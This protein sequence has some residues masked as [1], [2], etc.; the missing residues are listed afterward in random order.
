VYSEAVSNK[1]LIIMLCRAGR[2]I[3]RVVASSWKSSLVT[4]MS[5]ESKAN[6]DKLEL[7][8]IGAKGSARIGQ[9]A[10]TNKKLYV[11]NYLQSSLTVDV[12]I[13]SKD[14]SKILLIQRK[15]DPF[16]DHWAICGGFVDIA[17]DEEV[18]HAAHRELEEETGLTVDHHL[19]QVGCFA[20]PTRD[21]RGYTCTVVFA[22][23]IDET[24]AKPVA[25]DDAKT[26]N[27]F[28]LNDLPELA[29]DHAQIIQAVKS[30]I[31]EI[32]SPKL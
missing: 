27:W 18:E 11:Y 3:H 7:N 2:Q 5:T 29:F 12:A 15:A 6:H 8:I 4:N 30:R 32:P 10:G 19:L 9:V 16:K 23:S 14:K 17:D 22:A 24:L 13:L 28:S 20:G 31:D 1:D 25:G 21:P 26:V